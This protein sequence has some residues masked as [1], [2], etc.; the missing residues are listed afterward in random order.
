[1]K[2]TGSVV[3]ERSGKPTSVGACLSGSS[4]RPGSRSSSASSAMRISMRAR[5]MPRQACGP[6][7]KDGWCWIEYPAGMLTPEILDLMSDQERAR[8]LGERAASCPFD[9][10]REYARWRDMPGLPRATWKGSPVWVVNRLEDM[11]DAF[12]NPKISAQAAHCQMASVPRRRRRPG[13]R[14]GRL[15]SSVG[16]G[17]PDCSARFRAGP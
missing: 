4:P 9:P 11:R 15:R 8:H 10:P 14:S 16:A 12:T 2:T 3:G 17:S 1:M 13:L 5:C 7:P 6:E